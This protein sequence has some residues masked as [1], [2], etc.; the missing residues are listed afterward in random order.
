MQAIAAPITE[1]RVQSLSQ[2]GR[3]PRSLRGHRQIAQA[4]R[5]GDPRAAARKMRAH[6]ELVAQVA[7]LDDPSNPPPRPSAR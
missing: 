5:A 7:L 2:Q 6:I 4:I 1:S 3:P